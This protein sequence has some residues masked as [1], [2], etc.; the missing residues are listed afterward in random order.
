MS[1]ATTLSGPVAGPRRADSSPA[2]WITLA[3][4]IRILQVHGT[5]IQRVAL[6][7]RIGHRTSGF[8]RTLYSRADIESLADGGFGR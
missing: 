1:I 4:A 2:E 6:A 8:G 7:G 5:T 3:D